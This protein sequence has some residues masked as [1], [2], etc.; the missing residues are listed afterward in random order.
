MTDI[1][2]KGFLPNLSKPD[3]LPTNIRLRRNFDEGTDPANLGSGDP[4]L[5]KTQLGNSTISVRPGE[6]IQEAI[7]ET[8]NRGGGRVFLTP[9]TYEV[10]SHLDLKTGVTLE[11]ANSATT[12]IDFLAAAYS[13]RA[14]G[15]DVYDTGTISVN[16][17]SSTVTGS[18]T[19]WT[20]SMIGQSISLEG[21][22]YEITAVGGVTSLT[23]GTPFISTSG[24]GNL[25]GASYAIA[26]IIDNAAVDNLTIQNSTA[27]AI[28]LQYC[29]SFT[30][31]G[32]VEIE[33][34]YG[35]KALFSSTI[36]KENGG[37]FDC[38]Y[39]YFFTNSD[40]FSIISDLVY[41][42]TVGDGFRATTSGDATIF[43]TSFS[44][45]ATNGMTFIS[46]YNTGIVSFACND[47][48]GKGIELVSNTS[49]IE[50]FGAVIGGSGSDGIKLT[51]TSDTNQII[52]ISFKNN[53]GYGVNIAA[54]TCDNNVIV[55]NS[56]VGNTSGTIN[57]SGVGTK[58]K[59]NTGVPDND[60]VEGQ[61]VN[62][63]ISV[64]V[65]SNDLVVA[66]KTTAGN[67]PSASEPVF[68]RIN[69]VTRSVTAALSK[70]LA[71]GT[72][73]FNAGSSELATKEIDYFAYLGYNATDG[74]VL[75]YS[76]YPGAKQYGDFSATT[77]NEKY[78][79]ISTITNASSTDYYEVIGRFAA[80]LS[81]GAGYTWTVPTFTAI[82]LI[83]RPI[84]ETR[85]MSWSPQH[86]ASGSMTISGGT[87]SYA[88]YKLRE[89][90]LSVNA[91]LNNATLATSADVAIYSSLPFVIVSTGTGLLTVN[92]NVQ[93][94]GVGRADNTNL[95]EIYIYTG[96]AWTLSANTGYRYSF[97]VEI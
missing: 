26:T 27:P 14:I 79:A 35:L 73:W 15:T 22:Y 93:T 49:D 84:Y 25:S 41:G 4:Y 24:D 76:R 52:G 74:V 66:L 42:T 59:A 39:G 63:K 6:S 21:L 82:N 46:G 67:D 10:K 65:S 95:F 85:W 45:C 62:G 71:D 19:S 96:G 29:D 12:I 53:G 56:F 58:V 77:T 61:M 57:D 16:V 68:V 70:T 64:T 2:Q 17:N 51:A 86:T 88:K 97:T 69:G 38:E 3:L 87:V 60:I 94:S 34:Q 92:N 37:C 9:G 83:Q 1:F 5:S 18:G 91:V 75:G 11:G 7:D 90:I 89:N 72:N 47:N 54:S 44:S 36:I 8:N 20:S 23:I 80:I 31:N 32:V 28:D 13:I 48:A 40:G 81:A 55:G 30:S 43:N 33:C 50:M 78:C